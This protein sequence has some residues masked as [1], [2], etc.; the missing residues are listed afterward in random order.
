MSEADSTSEGHESIT[1]C[2]DCVPAADAFALVSDETRLRILEALW[3]LSEPASFSAIR[4][5]VG[6]RDSAKFN[7]HLGK[8]VG[9]FVRKT[10]DGYE[11]RTAGTRVVQAILSGSFTQHPDRDVAIHDP[12]VSCATPLTAKYQDEMLRIHCPACG[13][14]HGEYPFPPGGLHGRS[15]EEI[16][17]A[18]DQ[19]V[20]HLHCLAKDGVCPD[21]NGRTETTIV[22]GDDCCL[23]AGIH[24]IH[25]CQQ[26]ETELCSAVGLGL[27][28]HSRVVGFYESHGISLSDT[29]YWQLEW[30]VDDGCI[31]VLD[32][33]PWELRIE[34]GVG[35]ES[36]IL[37]IDGSLELIESWRE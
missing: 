29:P 20:R 34:I 4:E 15:D 16:L 17:R 23:G 9:P 8:L 35:N 13:H 21:C 33:D 36:I 30:C 1:E 24:A 11:L 31:T 2:V 22:R 19:R 14:G 26:C 7:Y 18:Y 25:E 12:C 32:E 6:S 37:E 27:L 3:Q 5:E 28:D 10:A